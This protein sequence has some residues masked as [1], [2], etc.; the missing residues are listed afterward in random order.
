MNKESLFLSFQQHF[1]QTAE[2]PELFFSPGRVNLIGE[3]TDYN[4]GEV[5]PCALSLGTYLVARKRSDDLVRMATGNFPLAGE[6]QLNALV[7]QEKDGWMN[8]PKGVLDVLQKNGH[9]FTGLDLYFWGDLPNG[10]GLSSSASIELATAVAVNE[11]FS[12]GIDRVT[13]VKYSQKAENEFVGVNCGIMDQFAIGMGKTNHALFLNCAS[14]AFE[15]VP[16]ALGDTKILISNTNHRRGLNE[17]KYNERRSECDEA[18]RLLNE[19]GL[20]IQWLSEIDLKTLVSKK[21]LFK[22][23]VIYQRAHHV[24]SEIERTK[25]AVATLKKGDLVHFGKLMSASHES[26]RVDYEVTGKALDSLASLAWKVPGVLGSRMTGAGFG[27]CTVTLIK[28]SAI[29]DFKK[30]VGPAYTKETGLVADFYVADIGN[31]TTR[32]GVE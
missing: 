8:Y 30:S 31:G 24:V 14:L 17:S 22:N 2:T 9:R 5:F 7:M 26:L 12:L 10:A 11:L 21:S 32:L 15:A 6:C 19:N 3:H 27:G 25:E 18:V 13:L 1:G 28:E 23:P 16:L 20:K 4:G 29:E